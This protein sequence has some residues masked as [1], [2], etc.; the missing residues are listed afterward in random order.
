MRHGEGG[1]Q[2]FKRI[3]LPLTAHQMAQKLTRQD[4]TPAASSAL[5][6][7]TNGQPLLQ[8]MCQHWLMSIL[9]PV[10]GCIQSKA[11]L[12][13]IMCAVMPSV[14]LQ[15]V[16]GRAQTSARSLRHTKSPSKCLWLCC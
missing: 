5:R 16:Q 3:I 10:R 11:S 2:D 6:H 4:G 14:Y 15:G 8:W 12:D 1:L 9:L 7:T 13:L